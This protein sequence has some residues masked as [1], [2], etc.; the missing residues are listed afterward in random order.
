MSTVINNTSASLI[1]SMCFSSRCR[2][3]PIN[4]II[5]GTILVLF[6]ITN[7][8]GITIIHTLLLYY[9]YIVIVAITIY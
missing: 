1:I 7:Y 4:S 9:C 2:R 5:I 3:V 8:Y 6:T